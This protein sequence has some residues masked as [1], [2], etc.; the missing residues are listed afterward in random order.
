MPRSWPGFR[1]ATLES[2]G[3]FREE[4]GAPR[5]IRGTQMHGCGS[6]VPY[7]RTGLAS[8]KCTK[9]TGQGPIGRR[10]KLWMPKSQQSYKMGHH[11]VLCA[12]SCPPRPGLG[13]W[14][15]WAN[16]SQQTWGSY[17]RW[18][19]KDK[20]APP[21]SGDLLR[22]SR[23]WQRRPT[24]QWNG[25]W[26]QQRYCQRLWAY[27]YRRQRLS[28]CGTSMGWQ[29]ESPSGTRKSTT[30]GT[31]GPSVIMGHLGHGAALH[32]GKKGGTHTRPIYFLW[33]PIT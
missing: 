11:R 13:H 3:S 15:T 29:E 21:Q 28:N 14:G 7:A 24:R 19:Q 16:P 10:H 32:S 20:P 18:Q 25:V 23:R 9:Y 30:N 27:K 33:D 1:K 6:S 17:Q 12:P 5:N 26:S 31:L 8:E 2:K 22:H 4:K